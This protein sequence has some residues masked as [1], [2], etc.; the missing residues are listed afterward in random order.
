MGKRIRISGGALGGRML[1]APKHSATRPTSSRVREALFNILGD[2][3]RGRKVADCFAG[4]GA[5]GLE[6]L[7]RGASSSAFFESDRQ[8]LVAIERNIDALGVEDRASVFAGRLPSTL[9]REGSFELLFLDPPWD[10]GWGPK[11]LARFIEGGLVTPGGKALLEERR[12]NIGPNDFT[13][14]PWRLDRQRV[15]GDTEL[16]FLSYDGG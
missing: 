3:V 6:A 15:Y 14:S 1:H 11:T 16:T 8:A 12:G 4:S 10:R 9:P 7:S 5:L 13:E 2:D